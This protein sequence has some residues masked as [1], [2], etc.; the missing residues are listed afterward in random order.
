[1]IPKSDNFLENITNIYNYSLV[2]PN[3]NVRKITPEKAQEA[4]VLYMSFFVDYIHKYMLKHKL[5]ISKFA[6]QANISKSHLHGILHLNRLPTFDIVIKI[7]KTYPIYPP[8]LFRVPEK[9]SYVFQ[10]I[11][12]D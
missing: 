2:I 11:T 9:N 10:K 3:T 6:S 8:D 12:L 7:C 4:I 5:S 1:M